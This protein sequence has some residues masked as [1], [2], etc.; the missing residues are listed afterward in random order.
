MLTE[1]VQVKKFH[2]YGF[3]C[4]GLFAKEDL[5]KGTLV[6]YGEDHDIVELFTKEDILTHPQRDTLITYSYM[7]GDDCK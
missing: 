4:T 6:W 1:V 2:D 3:E 7:R 5:K